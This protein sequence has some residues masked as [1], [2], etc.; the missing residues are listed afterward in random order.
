MIFNSLEFLI[1]LPIVFIIYWSFKKSVKAQNLFICIASYLFYGWWNYKF[2]F[3][4]ICTT[5]L[6]FASGLLIKR[7]IEKLLIT[8]TIN[9]LSIFFNLLILCIFK[10]YN[11]FS[12]SLVNALSAFG[13]SIDWVTLD[14]ILPVGIS[15]YTFQALSYTIDVYKKQIEACKD[16]I[17]FCAFISFFPQLV[18]GPIERAENLLTQIMKKRSFDYELAIDGC[19]QIIWGFF[20]KIVIAD[21]AAS[22]VDAVYSDISYYNPTALAI[23]A[24]LFAFQIYGDFSGY[25]D[26]AIGVAKLFGIRLMKNFNIP[27]FSRNIAEFWK[28]W[29]ISLNKWF[30][31]YLYIPLEGSKCGKKRQITNTLLVFAVSGLWHGANWTFIFWGLYHSLLFIPNIIRRQKHETIQNKIIS[32]DLFSILITFLLVTIGW[33]IFRSASI[34]EAYEF[35]YKLLEIRSYSFPN[36][37]DVQLRTTAEC[38]MGIIILITIE[39][40]YRNHEETYRLSNDKQ[41]IRWIIY[42]VLCL[43]SIVFFRSN[44]TFIYFQF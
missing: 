12:Q 21:T 34:Y 40:V 13:I 10:Y 28:R 3:L 7:Y 19:K 27:Y 23:T 15:F 2:L 20:K 17:A 18:A 31:N 5:F 37:N 24:V 9:I 30:I 1:F 16:P 44:Q 38:I 36:F 35:I 4:I 22:I 8:K 33:I 25:S 32:K 26:I 6:S 42:I 39:W 43:W 11:F 29:H 14:V 41:I